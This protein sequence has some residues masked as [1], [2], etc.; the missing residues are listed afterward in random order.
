MYI[1]KLK[2]YIKYII[3]KGG[4]NLNT[5][6]FT[7]AFAISYSIIF[8]LSKKNPDL[9]SDK[10]NAYLAISSIIIAVAD[11]FATASKFLKKSSEQ[12]K[13]ILVDNEKFCKENNIDINKKINSIL[14]KPVYYSGLKFF[15]GFTRI[16]GYVL[17]IVA[18]V[19]MIIWPCVE[20][21]RIES[22]YE[23]IANSCTL[24]SFSIMF[25]GMTLS[26]INSEYEKNFLENSSILKEQKARL[27][28]L[29]D[30]KTIVEKMVKSDKESESEL[31]KQ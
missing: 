28:L 29:K 26:N 17:Y 5:N 9:I 14:D 22:A 27:K 3:L 8:F 1:K 25:F 6:M 10:M 31:K 4:T 11:I 19:L 30:T 15:I 23:S 12:Q 18:F 16:G 21:K 7:M 20:I 2:L 13:E 24:I